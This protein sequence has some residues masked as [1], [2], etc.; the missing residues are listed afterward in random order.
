MRVLVIGDPHFRE[1]CVREME[2]F[3]EETLNIARNNAEE[4]DYIVVLGDVMD[5]H[6]ILHQK[7]FHQSCRFLIE[8]ASIKHTYCLI[9][10]HDFETPA[11]YLPDNHPYKIMVWTKTPNLTIVERPMVRGNIFLCPYVPPGEFPRAV[12]EVTGCISETPWEDLKNMGVGLIFAHQEFRGCQMGRLKSE[13][14]DL[15]SDGKFPFI[16]SGHIHDYQ[17]VGENILY[18]GTPIQVNYGEGRK[19][20]ICLLDFT[21]DE[22]G[23]PA[24]RTERWFEIH[25]PRKIVKTIPLEDLDAWVAKRFQTLLNRYSLSIKCRGRKSKEGFESIY[26]LYANRAQLGGLEEEIQRDRSLDYTRLHVVAGG[27]TLSVAKLVVAKLK[28]IP[29]GLRGVFIQEKE[30][31]T[32][33]AEKTPGLPTK[34]WLDLLQERVSGDAD[35]CLLLTEV[36]RNNA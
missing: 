36:L 15:W 12:S 30:S 31:P 19:R 28:L 26:E 29:L 8:L 9:G 1:G 13:T 6:G 24:T 34:T 16:V 4:Y 21:F 32:P 25:V 7:P 14:G 10:N 17:M 22:G 33:G 5:R 23:I 3:T 11:K 18:T 27:E 2:I 35:V 20:G